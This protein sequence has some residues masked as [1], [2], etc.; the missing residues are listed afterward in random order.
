VFFFDSLNSNAKR[1]CSSA[2][3]LNEERE[4]HEKNAI[5][6]YTGNRGVVCVGTDHAP[7]ADE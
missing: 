4:Y 5:E 2:P 7:A 3:Q 1:E 6:H